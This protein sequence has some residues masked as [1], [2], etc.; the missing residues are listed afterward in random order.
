[1]KTTIR[2]EGEKPFLY[3]FSNREAA[4]GYLIFILLGSGIIQLI[5]WV[6]SIGKYI[7]NLF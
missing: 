1:M 7:I 4:Y 6:W 3:V 5:K 2:Q